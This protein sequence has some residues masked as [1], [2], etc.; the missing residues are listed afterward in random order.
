LKG[1][2]ERILVV[3][4]DPGQREMLGVLLERLAYRVSTASSGQEALAIMP[5]EGF[6]LVILDMIM[7]PGMGGLETF[8]AI[9]R[10]WPGQRAIIASGYAETEDIR[11]SL[12]L[13]VKEAVLKPY[14][15]ERIGTAIRAA[16][17]S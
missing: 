12:A 16:L 10:R 13:G 14:T 1:S 2:G 7:E 3:D 6:D 5:E 17:R 8:E 9:L 11:R 15:I 4:D